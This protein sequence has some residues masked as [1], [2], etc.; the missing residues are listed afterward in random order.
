MIFKFHLKIFVFLFFGFVLFTI[1]GTLTHELGH[2]T[3]SKTLGYEDVKINYRSI[4]WDDRSET[5]E[6]SKIYKA[7]KD[8]IKNYQP[9]AEEQ[10]FNELKKERE[11]DY[12]WI[13][14]GGP[15]QT[16]TFGTIGLLLLFFRKKKKAFKLI[17]WAITFLSLFWLREVFNLAQG[18]ISGILNNNSNYFGTRGDEVRLSKMSEIWEGTI[19]IL[20]G[21]LG[22]VVSLIVIFY[23]I[24]KKIRFTF[25]LSGLFGGI[26]G[27]WFW[28]YFLGPIIMP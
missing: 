9:F 15:L 21:I 7:N 12:L 13:I 10:R 27:F 28:L 17:D 24:P 5:K 11:S 26:F 18:F 16:M 6:I 3:V 2:F 8:A 23:Y 4:S 20:F 25:I 22:L 19:P 14:F 1:I